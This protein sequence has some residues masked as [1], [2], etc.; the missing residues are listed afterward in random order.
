MIK[1]GSGSLE[2]VAHPPARP[3]PEW[4]C[5]KEAIEY[6]LGRWAALIRYLDDGELPI[7]NNHLEPGSGR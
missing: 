6:S 7:D 1:A 3:G 2:A 5:D 4:L